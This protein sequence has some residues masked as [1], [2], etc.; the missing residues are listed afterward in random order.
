[1]G[2]TYN[3]ND[4]DDAYLRG[5]QDGRNQM[6]KELQEADKIIILPKKQCTC[7]QDIC[8]DDE[9]KDTLPWWLI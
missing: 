2:K 4:L 5:V 9:P 3:S 6:L 7:K 1:M 8:V